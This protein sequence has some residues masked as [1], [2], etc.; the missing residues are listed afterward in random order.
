MP[1]LVALFA[2]LSPRLAILFVGIFTNRFL[3]AFDNWWVPTL[4][5][6]ILP[7][8]TLAWVMMFIPFTGVVEFGWFIVIFAFI[9]DIVTYTS[10]A[11][12]RAASS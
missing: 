5:F 12:R 6:F 8:T 7:W 10:S 9:I 4:G 1:C 11:A 2:I 3:F